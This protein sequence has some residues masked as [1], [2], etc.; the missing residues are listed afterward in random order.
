MARISE[1]AR[2]SV[3]FLGYTAAGSSDPT[4]ITPAGTGFLIYAG[5]GGLSG[6]YLV[7]AGHVAQKLR[8]DPFVI[9]LN[10]QAGF[11]RLDYIDS[12][13]WYYHSDSSVDI[14]VMRYEPPD[15]AGSV[16]FP[17]SEFLSPD[18]VEHW[19]VGPGDAVYLIGLFY[20]H[21][22][23]HR[24]LPVV[25]AGQ[26]ALL[27]SDEKIP[28]G[29]G[30]GSDNI[31]EVEAYLVEMHALTGASG[32]PVMIR[33]T[34]RHIVKDT[35]DSGDYSLAVSEG[36]DYLLGVWTAA[37]PGNP[38]KILGDA[39]GRSPVAWVPVGM[40]LV[41][42]ADKIIDILSRGDLIE[43]RRQAMA[44]DAKSHPAIHTGAQG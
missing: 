8:E 37:W 28:V 12:T 40:G 11:A 42:S 24:N 5:E 43:E 32:S 23:K 9:R 3:V 13:V 21:F 41:I 10:D 16:Y 35:R 6:V 38:D 44:S 20:L 34:L 14:A 18:R 29:K 4:A 15:W 27:P 26:I 39:A 17:V 1:D 19:E 33:P 30:D 22:G 7:T 31:E 2:N 25:Q 36:R